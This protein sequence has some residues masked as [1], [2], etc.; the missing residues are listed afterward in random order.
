MAELGFPV[1]PLLALGEADFPTPPPA[2]FAAAAAALDAK[3]AED[4]AA[5]EAVAGAAPVADPASAAGAA[6][7]S[8]AAG[9]G[10]PDVGRGGALPDAA[11]LG[12]RAS[13]AADDASDPGS[14][15][16]RTAGVASSSGRGAGAAAGDPSSS[17]SPQAG[18]AGGA[19]PR[20]A[21]QGWATRGEAWTFPP[22]ELPA[23][24]ADPSTY[25]GVAV[26]PPELPPPAWEPVPGLG[27]ELW[28]GEP[29]VARLRAWL[30]AQA[31]GPEAR[32]VVRPRHGGGAGALVATGLV[33]AGTMAHAIV[34]A[35]QPAARPVPPVSRVS[36]SHWP[37]F[38]SV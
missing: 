22:A 28:A 35:V 34:A 9:D 11:G 30:D 16:A 21:K 4:A 14:A 19:P 7:D 36:Q 26:P 12:P 3:R 31:L 2:L 32:L 18:A 29:W 8:G 15:A 27:P 20:A 23:G 10:G 24:A 33:Q 6:A 25:P 13:R 37:G 5:A 38:C 1:L 17:G